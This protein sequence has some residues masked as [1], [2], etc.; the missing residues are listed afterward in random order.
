VT[1]WHYSGEQLPNDLESVYIRLAHDLFYPILTT[2]HQATQIFSATLE[3]ANYNLV[4]V[5]KW[6][7]P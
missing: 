6:S 1:K 7:Y 4:D 2:W 5:L 3:S